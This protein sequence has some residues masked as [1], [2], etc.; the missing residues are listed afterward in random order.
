MANVIFFYGNRMFHNQRKTQ[1]AR[2]PFGD[3]GQPPI[4]ERIQ[5][6]PVADFSQEG[7]AKHELKHK[8]AHLRLFKY[9]R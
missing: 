7:T 9:V 5:G 3:V 4:T 1:A 8:A 2:I 6:P